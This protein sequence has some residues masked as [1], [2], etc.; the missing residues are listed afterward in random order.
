MFKL[1]ITSVLA[2]A[3]FAVQAETDKWVSLGYESAKVTTGY[4]NSI[5]LPD[6]TTHALSPTLETQAVVLHTGTYKESINTWIDLKMGYGKQLHQ[7]DEYYTL[8]FTLAFPFVMNI[9]ETMT[10]EPF[11]SF[12]YNRY[13]PTDTMIN[14]L[15]GRLGFKG[16]YNYGL[17][18]WNWLIAYHYADFTQE[19]TAY[20]QLATPV[21]QQK[22]LKS[23]QTGAA[24]GL[25][26]EYRFTEN[27]SI[28][29]SAEYINNQSRPNDL[30]WD[31]GLKYRF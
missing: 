30:I 7:K 22:D 13:Y 3:S 15:D 14:Q 5:T 28:H 27:W 9:N 23:T 2:F 17:W 4:K 6:T 8:G 12:N 24:L 20:N 11:L 31:T 18:Q 19:F 21:N 25:G 10:L 16:K 26:G 29:T 1:L